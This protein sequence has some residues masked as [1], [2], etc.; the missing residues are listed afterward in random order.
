MPGARAACGELRQRCAEQDR[1]Q[2]KAVAAEQRRALQH[3]ER[4]APA[5]SGKVPR[6]AGENMPA[7]PFRHAI[8]D[9]ENENPRRARLPESHRDRAGQG[10]EQREPARQEQFDEGDLPGMRVGFDE[11]RVSRPSRGRRGTARTPS[12][13][14]PKTALRI[15][16]FGLF[17]PSTR[18]TRTATASRNSGK[19][20]KG[21]KAER[22]QRACDEGDGGRRQPVAVRAENHQS[23]SARHARLQS[24]PASLRICGGAD[25]I[26]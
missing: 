8:R 14:R 25:A 13:I 5:I 1:Q 4:C 9:G 17:A 26:S 11:K 19:I 12:T 15:G 2:R 18:R 21:A 10:D 24:V 3:A 20:S 7:H 16:R 23:A 22:R 6:K